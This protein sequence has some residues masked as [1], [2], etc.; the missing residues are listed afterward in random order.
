MEITEVAIYPIKGNSDKL[1]AFAAI[2]IDSEF[3]IK[4]LKVINGNNGLFVAM[5]NEKGADGQYYDTAFPITADCRQYIV[6]KIL[7]EYEAKT[8]A[9]NRSTKKR[10]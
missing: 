4:G 7:E 8:A 10:K 3:V 9:A 1:K 5:P 6:E 2:T